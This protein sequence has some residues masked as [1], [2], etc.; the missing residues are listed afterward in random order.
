MEGDGCSP[1]STA[2][3]FTYTIPGQADSCVKRKM[4][5]HTIG[6]LRTYFHYN[7]LTSP[8]LSGV[9]CAQR[10]WTVSQRRVTC[11]ANSPM[12]IIRPLTTLLMTFLGV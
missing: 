3:T 1:L 12:T 9:A 5:Y 7:D 8:Q 10:V 2:T 11:G 4:A 6:H